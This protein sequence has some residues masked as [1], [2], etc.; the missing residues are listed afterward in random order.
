MPETHIIRTAK[1]SDVEHIASCVSAAYSHYLERMDKPP[2]PM[3]WD[4]EQV[5]QQR[6]V[7]V[8][9]RH[10]QIIG[11]I[12]LGTTDEGFLL[13]NVAVHP[14]YQGQGIGRMLLEFAEEQAREQGFKTI[15]L[16]TNVVM[17]ENQAMYGKIGYCEYER[18]HDNG[19]SRVYMRKV[20]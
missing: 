15:H 8:I 17:T 19:Y 4:Y 1:R 11:V 9:E 14:Q 10:N 18:R 12:V 6:H 3:I 5:I 7:S 2:P 13:D 20:L 16:C